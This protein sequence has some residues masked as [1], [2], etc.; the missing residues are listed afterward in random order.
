MAAISTAVLSQVKSGENMI[1][2]SRPYSGTEKLFKEV[3]P[4]YGIEVTYVDG[5]NPENFRKKIKKNTKAIY[6]SLIHI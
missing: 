2:V 6:L 1:S 4:N 3:L 5:Q